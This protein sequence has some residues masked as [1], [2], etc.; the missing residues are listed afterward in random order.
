MKAL[1]LKEKGQL[2]YY[3]DWDEPVAG[4][5]K[6][7]VEVKAAAL[8][9]R[10]VWITK[11]MYPGIRYPVILGS[12][13]AG[14]AGGREVIINPGR[15]WGADPAAQSRDYKILGLPDDGT[16]AG[17]VV[18]GEDRLQ[19]KPPHLSWEEAAAL[20]LCGLTA[21]R[22]VFSRGKLRA[23]ERVL[24]SGIG[25][26]V[27]VFAFQFALAAGAEVYVTSSSGEKIE[28]AVAMGAQGG[29]NYREENWTGT[30]VSQAGGFD[31][32]IDGAGG[33]GFPA[34]L[35]LVN[36]GARIVLYGG[37]RGNIPKISPQVIFW[38]QLNILG[39]TMGNDQDFSDMVA[40]V[41]EH[42]IVPVVDHVFPLTEGQAAFDRMDQG[43]QFGKIV[44]RI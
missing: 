44:L 5:G 29:A 16:F 23:G 3:S 18:V 7:A 19:P 39:S 35:K 41:A 9:H 30:L 20:P 4:S 12:D 2:H 10:D 40:F 37:H 26:G 32:I 27:A 13:G 28:K 38:K 15:D 36:S 11:E 31:L 33:A 1:V 21:F 6:I 34:F 14:L 24:I 8:N 22:A 17:R 42:R 25:G 43:L